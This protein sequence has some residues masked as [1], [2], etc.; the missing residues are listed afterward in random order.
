[1]K[2]S[3]AVITLAL[4]LTWGQSASGQD[5]PPRSGK[6]VDPARGQDSLPA[7][8][9]RAGATSVTYLQDSGAQAAPKVGQATEQPAAALPKP[10]ARLAP[11]FNFPMLFS[12]NFGE[13]RANHF[14]GG[15]DFKT[16]GASGKPMMAL[17]TGYI[18]RI[19]VTH[20]SGY[21]LDVTYDN[22]YTTTC[23]HL[24]AFVGD[25]ARRV[26]EIQYAT[27][28]WEMDLT[29]LPGEYPVE[30]GQVIA[31]SGNTGYSF[32]P[33]LHLDVMETATGD[34]I[35][36]LPLF[37][38]GVTD[39][40]A[41]RAEGLLLMPQPGKGTVEGKTANLQL[42]AKPGRAIEA[43]GWVGVAIKA[44]DYM[45][46]AQN[47]LGVHTLIMEVD[48]EERFRSV[49]DRF[50]PSETRYINSWTYQGY[51]KTFVDPGNHLRMLHTPDG[52]NGLIL[53]DEERPYH[54]RLTLRDA[55]GNTSQVNLTLKGV[56]DGRHQPGTESSKALLDTRRERNI[57]RWDRV[58]V[59]QQPGMQLV[60]TRGLLYADAELSLSIETDTAAPALTY[61]FSREPIYLHGP[62]ELCIALRRQPVADT[63]K[64]YVAAISPT[65]RKSSLGGTFED[66]WIRTNVREL[67]AFTVCVDTIPPTIT[68]VNP[69]G[70]GRAGRIVVKANDRETGVASYRATIDGE[71]A[72]MGK[73]NSISGDLV[74]TLDPEHVRRG[75][76]H[77]LVVT[78]RDGCGNENSTTVHFRW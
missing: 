22:G 31:K 42:P 36:P 70:W 6:A 64:Y 18:S 54:V 77:E 71:Y 37:N 52:T 67:T 55:A 59:V 26:K 24:S 66:G 58:N 74:C 23:R 38:Y 72:L 2:K 12:G 14:H 17:G 46:G 75:R 29:P 62:A 45:D 21:V 15:L 40:I 34:H 69:A 61:R 35:D 51:M 57:L 16:Q 10:G 11:P 3:V 56:N 60:V 1:M 65:G 78:V 41:P 44:Y 73:P 39:H 76:Q 25:F 53:I 48:G 27:E 7:W 19:R 32:G 5:A 4:A 20:G 13:L 8:G 9:E 47:R 33:H 68:P 49:V 30:A 63:R 43:W 50:H 28:S